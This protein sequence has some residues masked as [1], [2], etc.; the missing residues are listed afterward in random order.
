MLLHK[1]VN[2]GSTNSL[3]TNVAVIYL[4][5]MQYRACILF[6][7]CEIQTDDIR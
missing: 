7:D 5:L 2:A 1:Y 4:V 3:P 6:E